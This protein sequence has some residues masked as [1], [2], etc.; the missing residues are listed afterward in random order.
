MPSGIPEAV[1]ASV[2]AP[3]EAPAPVEAPASKEV[4]ESA[5]ASAPVEA[6]A[7]KEVPASVE[8]PGSMDVPGSPDKPN[9]PAAN[10]SAANA[11]MAVSASTASLL[12][13]FI[14]LVLH[15]P[16][17][18][19][20]KLQPAMMLN[21]ADMPW[22]WMPAIYVPLIKK[23][24]INEI[25]WIFPRFPAIWRLQSET[26]S[27]ETGIPRTGIIETGIIELRNDWN[28]ESSKG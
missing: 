18:K 25:P 28:T 16:G 1:P 4:A 20:L 2:P 13:I 17:F 5:D 14:T 8:M 15:S 23:G 11:S 7:S 27:F 3:K 12:L 9:P 10:G 6:P 26:L 22:L 21:R 19:K 24:F